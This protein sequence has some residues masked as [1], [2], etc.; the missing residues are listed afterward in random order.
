M[1]LCA[2][3]SVYADVFISSGNYNSST[4]DNLQKD[5]NAVSQSTDTLCFAHSKAGLASLA[6]DSARC[7]QGVVVYGA[8]PSTFQM[9]LFKCPVLVI[10]G[11]RDGV[12]PMS[13]V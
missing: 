11:T 3:T 9:N 5:L 4:Y 13:Q 6:T 2:A 1:I 7:T 8:V 10:G 12:A